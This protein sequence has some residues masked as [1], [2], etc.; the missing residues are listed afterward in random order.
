MN[1]KKAIQL[2]KIFVLLLVFVFIGRYLYKNINELKKL[3]IKI[4]FSVFIISMI[5]FWIYK[6]A[7]AFLWHYITLL[8]K[9]SIPVE[10]A[11]IA[12]MYSLLWKFIPGKV[13]YLGGRLYF[14]HNEGISKTK[15]SFCF[16]FEN[17]CTLV[18]AAFLFIVS[19]IFVNVD[20]L[21][22]YKYISV[23][24]LV[25][26][27]II[28]NPYF[29]KTGI[30]LLLKIFRKEPLQLVISYMDILKVVSLFIL[31]WIIL[32]FGFYLLV[33]S[34]YPVHT[35]EFFFITGTYALACI[36]GILSLFA[37]SGIGVRE[38]IIVIALKIIIPESVTI[39]ISIVSRIWATAGELF[40][41]LLTFI[42][43]KFRRIKM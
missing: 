41:V 18:A 32:G 13:F 16:I 24:L 40:L 42:Y 10:K 30:N 21:N 26:F 11:V 6:L 5:T 25:L 3:E 14:Y 8:A 1:K 35:G 31:N 28:I 27:F 22:K 12:W 43:A 34:I 9:C 37:P 36:I 15:I 17:I 20:F 38:S 39:V 7:N 29:F 4:N 19:L 2:I 23:F 33:N